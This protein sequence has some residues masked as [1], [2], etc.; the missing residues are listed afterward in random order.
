MASKLLI[1]GTGLLGVAALR[2]AQHTAVGLDAELIS[3]E[4]VVARGYGN[5]IEEIVRKDATQHLTLRPFDL[6]ELGMPTAFEQ[7]RFNGYMNAR[8]NRR[9]K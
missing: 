2:Q 6:R 4:D 7:P 8:H 1:V 5:A 9:R 3:E